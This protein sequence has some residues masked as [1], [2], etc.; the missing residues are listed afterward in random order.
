MDSFLGDCL[1]KTVAGESKSLSFSALLG[2][3]GE[4]DKALASLTE[5]GTAIHRSALSLDQ[6]GE[7]VYTEEE[8][9]SE[10]FP[11]LVRAARESRVIISGDCSRPIHDLSS[12]AV[13]HSLIEEY[14]GKKALVI[15]A[16]LGD[17]VVARDRAD[18]KLLLRLHREL[19]EVASAGEVVNAH[20]IPRDGPPDLD[21]QVPERPDRREVARKDLLA[22]SMA[23]SMLADCCRSL[24]EVATVVKRSGWA[25]IP[26]DEWTRLTAS[27]LDSIH[28]I[29]RRIPDCVTCDWSTD[30][31]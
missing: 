11:D 29:R 21:R 16:R 6:T 9:T 31:F 22:P 2:D 7:L 28:S 19:K 18:T 20:G 14:E 1:I 8:L 4:V 13:L 23:L 3:K 12:E 24:G 25:T 15:E 17:R 26:V 27:A 10:S 30:G 5:G